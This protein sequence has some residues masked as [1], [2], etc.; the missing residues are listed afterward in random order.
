[1][2]PEWISGRLFQ[3][4]PGF[5]PLM[6]I[7]SYSGANIP[8]FKGIDF[9]TGKTVELNKFLDTPSF[10]VQ[11]DA[12]KEGESTSLGNL[13]EI[14]KQVQAFEEARDPYLIERYRKYGDIAAQQQL[15]QAYQL[16]PLLSSVG[17]EATG[18]ALGASQA[19]AAFKEQLPSNVQKITESIQGQRAT[20]AGAEAALQQATA[21]QQDAATRFAGQGLSRYANLG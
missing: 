6:Q 8:K 19:Y 1:M 16:R 12:K 2:N 18:R 13:F 20:A 7:P 14:L 11:Q 3:Q 17:A 15:Q 9:N 5:A 4:M 10:G 21:M